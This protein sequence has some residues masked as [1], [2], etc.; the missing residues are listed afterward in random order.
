MALLKKPE[1]YALNATSLYRALWDDEHISKGMLESHLNPDE[2]GATNNHAF[3]FKSAQWIANLAPPPQFEKLLDLGCGPG[4]YAERFAKEGYSVTGVDYS[5]RS[6]GYAKEQTALCQYIV[7]T[8]EDVSCFICPNHYLTK[9]ILISEIQ[10]VGFNMFEFYG[11][12]AGKEYSDT[13]ET[14]CCIISKQNSQGKSEV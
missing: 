9:D 8:D 10:P 11:D 6:I 2:D 13:G 3:V 7:V 4:I 12:I 5:K 1:L 14:I